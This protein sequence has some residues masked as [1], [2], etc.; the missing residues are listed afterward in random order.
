M[1]VVVGIKAQQRTQDVDP[2][3]VSK[4]IY[5]RHRYAQ[6]KTPRHSTLLLGPSRQFRVQTLTVF[7]VATYAMTAQQSRTLPCD[8]HALTLEQQIPYTLHS[9]AE[10]WIIQRV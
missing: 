6:Y 8:I 2:T 1:V 7:D 5:E 3:W 9:K 10:N 4:S